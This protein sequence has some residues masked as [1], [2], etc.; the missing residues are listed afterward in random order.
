MS[1]VMAGFTL[2]LDR[3]LGLN[4]MPSSG[5]D[6]DKHGRIA[7]VKPRAKDQD[8]RSITSSSTSRRHRDSSVSSNRTALPPECPL[9]R[10][11]STSSSVNLD[12]LP[13]LPESEAGSPSSVSSPM[14]RTLSNVSTSNAMASPSIHRTPAFLQAYLESESDLPS[15]DGDS[16]ATPKAEK[17]KSQCE[18]SLEPPKSEPA[19]VEP[20]KAL[21]TPSDHTPMS[22]QKSPPESNTKAVPVRS[23]SRA[24]PPLPLTQETQPK[25]F[26]Q[27]APQHPAPSSLG[28][29]SAPP[30]P[31]SAYPFGSG[32]TGPQGF[33]SPQLTYLPMPQPPDPSASQQALISQGIIYYPDYGSPPPAP[34]PASQLQYVPVPESR[35]GTENPMALLH[36]VDSAIPD[37]HRLLNS[38][39]AIHDVLESKEYHIHHMEAQRTT[40][41]QVEENRYAKI[42]QQVDSMTEKHSTEIG[43][44]KLDII[45]MDKRC[46][47]LRDKLIAEETHNDDL[48]SANEILRAERKQGAKKHEEEKAALLYKASLE[49]DRMVAEHRAKQRASHDEL[50][51]Q[52]RKAEASLSHKEAYLNRAHEEEKRKL[53]L[54]W[55]KQNRELEHRHERLL[56]DLAGRLEAKVK[57]IEEERRTYLQAR[58]GW[59]R[60]RELMTSRWEE[61]RGLLRKTSE[62]QQNALLTRYEREKNDILKQMA[63][64]QHRTEKDD[65]SLK[66]QREVEALR[67]GWE[68]DKFRFQRTTSEFKASA[69]TLNEHNNKLQKLT[70]GLS[71]AIDVKGK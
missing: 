16:Q 5:L 71:D 46:K 30:T 54:E 22:T 33:H 18:P 32:P 36:R 6:Y 51:A 49:K 13:A 69:R 3:A 27:P 61:E 17:S 66:L 31:A 60:E 59:D 53:E 62:D 41:K 44:L 45:N 42:R 10:S 1:R 57:V 68:A 47:D 8:S 67:A 34:N 40:E 56:T 65:A 25:D 37:L 50:Q 39:H 4:I 11:E 48:E 7:R 38:Y 24:G 20:P 12:Q 64:M 19:K 28:L 29:A 43:Q 26:R 14:L 70:E 55:T 2:D 15:I 58:E 52:I 23:S 35:M 63:Q 9:Q 21:P